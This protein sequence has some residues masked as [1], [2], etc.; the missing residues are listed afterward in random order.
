MLIKL[1][2]LLVW[3]GKPYM[4]TD[5]GEIFPVKIAFSRRLNEEEMINLAAYALLIESKNTEKGEKA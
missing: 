5:A 2:N 1:G 4:N 3:Q